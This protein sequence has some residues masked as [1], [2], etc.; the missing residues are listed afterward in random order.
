[1]YVLDDRLQ[2]VPVGVPGELYVAGAGVARGYL[3][4]PGLTGERFVADPFTGGRMYRTGD[5]VRW[6]PDGELLFVGRADDQ[7]KIRGYRVEPGEV[8]AV[9]AAHPAVAQAAVLVRE[10][11]PG[12]RRLIAYLVPAETGEHVTDTVR[13]HVEERLPAY[14]VPAAFVELDSLPLTGN[15]K[16]DRA[17]LPAPDWTA[18]GTGRAPATAQQELL[19]Q[20]FADVLDLPA[21]GSDDDFFAL[22]GHS[23]LATRLVGRVRAV[24]GVELPI[25]AL[26]EARTPA[27]LAD[28]LARAGAGRVALTAR[29]RPERVPLSFAQRRLWFL[30][31]LDGPSATYNIPVALRL[32]GH[33]DRAALD[34]AL[35]DVLAR[36]EVLRTGYAVADGEPYQRVLPVAETG[37][38]VEVVEVAA[39]EVAARVAGAAAYPFDLAAE[40]PLRAT[41]LAVAPDE[42]VLVLVVHHIAGDGASMAPL[43]ADV[44]AAYAARLRGEAPDW[45]PLPVQYADYALWQ[46]ELLGAEDDPDSLA[47][48][49]LDH[50]RRALAGVPE[51]LDLPADRARPTEAGHR[52]HLVDLDVP[53]ELHDRLHRLARRH[54][55]T[56]YM[57]LQAG[58]AVLLSR[59]GAGTDVPIGAAVAGRTDPALDDLV[60]FFVNT[61]V[62]RTDLTGDPTVAEVLARVRENSLQALAHQDVPFERLVEELAP[63][64]SLARHPL[65]QVML[66]LQNADRSG[67]PRADL[68]GLTATVV[69]T[70]AVPAKFD[71][72]V[73]FDETYDAD[74][75]PAGLRGALIA[76]ADLFEPDTAARLADRLVRMLDALTRDPGRRL[77][78]LPLLDADERRRILTEW[79]AAPVPVPDVTLP[80]LFEAQAARTPDA[81]ALTDGDTRLTYA[82]LDARADAVARRLVGHGVGPESLV[83]VVMAR[84]ADLVVALLGVL[85]AGAAY[86]PIDPAYPA[87]RIAFVLA[88]AAAACVLTST[89]HTAVVPP[90][91]PVLVLDEPD[92]A[93][94]AGAGRAARIRPLRPEHPAYVIYTSGSTGTPK[95]VLVPHRDVVA[96]FAA[97]GALF[98]FRADDVWSWFHSFAFDFSV[99]EIWGGL[100]H[101]GR[102][103]VVPYAVSRSPEEFADL[104]AREGVTMLSQTPSAFY[105]LLAAGLRP[106]A[107]RA[108]VFGGEALDPARLAGWWARHGESGPRLVNMY[109]ITET[110]VHV[111][112]QALE[113][114]DVDAGS[115]IGRG[116]PGLRVHL[117]DEWLNPVP[118]GVVGELYV[119][120]A[121]LARGYVGRAGLT[122]ERFVACPFVPGERMYRTGDR[123]RWTTDG[124]LVF[125]GRAD[126]QVKIRGFRIEPGEVAAVLAEHPAV[127]QAAVVARRDTGDTRLVGYL[128]PAEGAEEADLAGSV[129]DFAAARL[130][131]Y[132]VPSALVVLA[133]L[134]LTVNGKLDRKALPAPDYAGAAGAGRAPATAREEQICQAFAEVL[135]IDRVGVDDDFFALGG[136]S[137]LAVSLVERLRE[138]GVG[139]SVRA[140]FTTPTP[141]GLA[142]V[143]G[144]GAVTV[145]PNLIPDGADEIT[146]AML[147]LVDL[148]DAEVA[149]VVAAV[150]GGAANVADVYPLAP[151]QE[152]IF[153][154]HLLGDG[155]DVY[156]TPTVVRFD[157]RDRLDAFLTALRRVVDRNDVYRTAIVHEGLREPVQV[158]LRHAPLPV[159]EVALDPAGADPVDQ[160]LAAAG[161]RM[162]L[163]TAPLLHVH[164]A[165]EA[166][167]A[168]L[169]L[170]RVHHLVQDHTALDVV[171][172]QLQAFLDGRGDELPP[173]VP[174]REF[175]AQARLGLSREAHQ[176]HFARLLGDVTEPTA[177]YGLTDVH[178]DG[179]AAVHAHVP[180]DD[181]LAERIRAVA[182]THGVSPATVFHLAWARVLGTVSGRD[183]VVFGSVL[184]GRMNAGAGADR[185][186]GLFINT[187]PVRVRLAGHAVAEALDGL[188]EQ[189]A[190]LLVHEHAP[191]ALAQAAS[192]LPGGSPVFTSIFN[193]RHNQAPAGAGDGMRG[194][195]TVFA[196]EQTNYPLDVAVD[197]DGPRFGITATAVAPVDPAQVC[198]M[199]TTALTNLVTAL[200]EAPGTPLAAIGV[201]DADERRRVLP[202]PP[203]G[204]TPTATVPELIAARAAADPGALAVV[205][206]G[207]ALTYA[208]LDD[209]S[210]RLAR[211]LLARGL[212]AESVVGL[213]LP[214]GPEMVVAVVAA[215]RAGVGYVPLDPEY[216]LDRLEFMLADSGAAL[217]AGPAELVDRL[218]G[219]PV[220]RLDDLGPDDAGRPLPRVAPEQLA[221]VIYT[222]GSTGRPK[223]VA[224]AHAA[225]ASMAVHYGPVL[226]AA[227]GVRVLQFASF[228]FDASVLDVAVTLVAGGTLVVAAP[229][230]RADTAQLT[231]LVRAQGVTAT[232]VVPSLLATLDPAELPDVGTILV[233]AEPISTAQARA[234]SA[235]RNLVNTY[236]P[237]EATVMVTAGAVDVGPDGRVP[238][239]GPVTGNRLVVLDD[240]LQPVPVGVTGELYV[241]GRQLARGYVGRPA[242]TAER[243]VACP[244]APGERMYRTGDRAWWTADGQL[245][246]AGRA[247]DQVKIRGFRIEPGEVRAVLAD[248][249]AVAQAAVVVRE[250][251]PGDPRLVAYL[252]PAEDGAPIADTV[253]EHAAERLPAYLVPAAFVTL[254]ALPLT[255]NGKLDRAALPAPDLG[256]PA[257]RAP[258]DAREELLCAAFADVLG[259]DRVAVDDDFFTL[260][261]H[262]LLATRLVSRVRALLGLEVPIRALFEARTP[263]ALAARLRDARAGRVALTARPRPARVPLS[264][265]QRRLWFLGQLEGPSATYDIPVALRLTGDLDRAALDA[266]V[267]DVLDR[268]EVLRTVYE[269]ADG[270]PHQRVLAVAE[271]GVRVEV[272]EVR[273]AELAA[274]VAEAA[275]YPFDLAAEVP[276]RVTLFAV[277]PDEHVLVLVVH[278]IAADGWS[279]GPLSR[280]VAT[281]YAARR[282]GRTPDWTPL[283]VQYADYALW[284]RELLGAEDDPDSTVARQV[285]HWRAVLA[286][287]PEELEL[288]TDRPRPAQPSYRGHLVE[289]DVPAALHRDLVGLAR[290]A[291]V[292]VFMAVQAALAV[293]LSRLGAGTDVPIGAAV[294]GR[295]D[296]GLD[297]LVGFFVNTLVM[298]TDLSGDPTVTEL[299]ARVRETALDAYAH[300]DVPFERLVEELAPARSLARH[301]LFQVLLTLQNLATGG[302]T[303][304]RL[305][306]LSTE[307]FPT[308]EV[309][310]KFDLDVSLTE[311]YD[312]DGAPAGMRGT[313]IAAA[314]LFDRHTV[315]RVAGYLVRVLAGLAADPDARL[316]TVDV[317]DPAEHRRVVEEWN[318]TDAPV[319]AR[320]VAD[321]IRDR[322][323]ATPH[324]LALLAGETRLDHA[325][326]AARVDRLAGF[327][328]A[329]GARPGALVAICLDRT[330]DLV[331]ALLAVLRTGA[332]YLPID[333]GYPA[334][335]VGWMLAD[336][337]PALLLTT[338]RAR[339]G[340]TALADAAGALLLDDPATVAELA[341]AGPAP[342]AAPRPEHPAYVI[343]T[344]G[345][346]GRPKGVVVPHGALANFLAAMA[347]TTPLTPADR[348]LAVTT[349]AFD[350]HVLEL[351][352][353]LLAGA[354]VVLADEAVVRD[355]AAAAALIRRAGVTVA[356]AT[357]A[358]WHALAAGHA[359]ALAGLRVLVG[360]EALPPAQAAA[361][362]AR[363]RSVTNLY[364][365]TEVTVWATTAEL[366]GEPAG[367]VPIGRPLWNTRAYVLDA[368]L[369]PVPVGCPGELYLAGDQVAQGYHGRPDLTAERFVACPYGA[370]GERMYRTGDVVRWRA[371]GSLAFVG[372][373]DDQV[374]IR[375]F[376]IELG[377]VEAA[378]AGHPAVARATAV[379]REDSPG[380]RRLVG[381]VVPAGAAGVDVAALRGHLAGRLPAYLVPS[382][383]VV[384]DAL[385]LT[386]NGKVDRRALPAPDHA[387]AAGAGRAPADAREEL[388][389]AAFAAVLGLPAVGMDDDFFAL[390]GHSLLAVALVEHLRGLGVT[391][392]VRALFTTPTPAG[393]AAATGVASVPVPPNRIPD[394]ARELGPE[395]LP[396]VD[397]TPEELAT[398]VAA[399]PGGAANV[400]DV[401]PLAPLQEGILFHHLMAD[402]DGDDVYVLP[403]VLR[404]ATRDRLDDFLAALSAVVRRH[405][406]YRTAVVW[407]GLREPVQVVARHVE[408]P[409][410]EVSLAG[411][412]DP[413]AALLADGGAW[414][415]LDRPPLLRMRVAAEPGTG[416]WLGLLRIHHLVQDHTALEALLAEVLAFLTGRGHELPDPLPFRE[417][418]ARARHGAS[419]D[420]Q[421]AYFRALLGDV[422]ETT[423]P[424][425]LTDAHGDAADL[426]G[427]Q[428]L[429]ADDLATRVRRLGRSHGVSPAT[430]FH[431]AWARV[432]GT[433][434]GRDDVVFGTVL[435]G[436]LGAGGGDARVL[437]PFINTLPVRV[438]LDD[439]TGDA[440]AALR[441]QLAELLAHEHAPLTLAQTA[442]GVPNGQPLF[443][444]LFNFRHSAPPAGGPADDGVDGI[445]QVA[446][447]ERSNYPVTVSVD[448]LGE[449]FLLSVDAVA[450][451]DPDDV[452]ALLHTCLAHLV[453][454]LTDAPETPLAAVPVLDDDGYRRLVEEPNRTGRGVPALTVPAAFAAQ[455]ARTPDGVALVD[456]AGAWTYAELDARAGRLAR[457]LRDRGVGPETVVGVLLDRSAELV[458][459]LLAILK[460]GGAYLPVDPG[461]PAGRIADMVADAAPRLLLTT[462]AVTTALPVAAD[463]LVLDDPATRAAL[464]AAD[465]AG[466]AGLRPDHPAYVM[467]T[468]GSTGRP[469]GVVVP[470]AAIDRLV[471]APGVAPLGPGD[472]VAQLA[473]VSFDAAT[474]E[475]WGAL[476]T[477]ATLAVAPPGAL[478]VAEL[479]AFLTDQRVSTLWL[480]AGLFHEVVDADVTA[481]AGL[482][483]LLAGGD[484]LSPAHCRALLDRL[485]QVQLVNGYGPTE[486]TTF[487]TVHPVRPDELSGAVPIGAPIPDTSVYVL[488]EALRPVPAGVVGELYTAGAGLARGYAGP[489][490]LTAERFVA[491]PFT[492]GERMYRTGDRVRR[493]PDGR[494]V[495]VGRADAQVKLRGFRVE[496][497]EAEAVLAGHPEV[498]RAV[499]TVREDTPGEKR[500]VAYVVP[501]D[502]TAP[503][504]ALVATLRAHAADRLP[505]YLLPA[506]VVPLPALPLTANGKVDRAALP[507]PEQGAGSGRPAATAREEILCGIFAEVLGR[508]T[509]GPDDDF[510]ALGGHSLLVT[511][512]VSRVRVVL[513]AELPIR[514][515]FEA[516]TPAGLADRLARAA[517]PD[518]PALTARPRPDRVPLSYAQRRLWFLG[519]LEGPNA[520]YNIPL[521]QRIDGPVDTDALAAA[522][523]DVVGRHEVLRTVFPIADGEPY[524]R[525]L[526]LDGC[527]FALTVVRTPADRLAD[528]AGEAAATPFDLA[529]DLP[530][531]AWLFTAGP[532]EHVLVLLVHHVAGDGWSMAPLARDLATAYAARRAGRAPEWTP[533]PVQYADYALWQRDLLGADDD[534][535]S[536]LARQVAYWRAALDGAPEEL[537][538]P[539]DR[540]RPAEAGHRGHDVPLRVPAE[541]HERLREVARAEGVTVFMVLQAAFATLLSRLGAGRDVPIGSAIAGRTDQ[542]LDELVGFFVNTLV[543][544]TDLS[545]DPTFRR[546]L[547][548]VR[549]T[550]LAAYENQDVPFERLVEELAPARSLARH[551]IFQVMLTLQNTAAAGGE[552]AGARTG[553]LPVGLTAAKFDLEVTVGEA[554][555][556]DGTPAGLHGALIAAADLFDPASA[557]RI[558]DRLVRVL[559]AVTQ[560]PDLRV[561]QV[562]VLDSDERR[563]VL[564][565]WN[566]SALPVPYTTVP[567]LFAAQVARTPDAT[568]VTCGATRLTYAELDAR[569]NR[570]ARHLVGRGVGPESVVAVCLPR[571][572]DTIAALL[573]V[574]KAGAAYLPVDPAYPADR[575]GFLLGDAEAVCVLTA[576]GAAAALPA[577]AP[578]TVLL[579]DPAVAAE[580]AGL[581]AADLTDADRR[582]PLLPGHRA[583][584]IYTSG[585]TGRPKGVVVEHRTAVGLLTWAAGAFTREEFS[586]VLAATSLNFDVSVFELFGPLVSGGS[587][588]VVPDL[589]ALTDRSGAGWSA[590]LISAVPS[591]LSR[592]LGDGVRA[593]ARTV[594]L[595]GEALTASAVN[596]VR[597]ALPGVRVANIY[598]PTEATVYATAWWT[599]DDVAGV[600]PVGRPIANTRAY[601]L[602][603]HLTPV[604][605]GVVGELYLAGSQLARGYLGRAGLTG[606]RFVACPFDTGGQRMYRT[607]D[608]VRWSADGQ[609][610]FAGRVDE[611]VK[612]RG[613]RIEP[614]EVQAALAAHPDVAEAVVLAR[615]DVPGDPRLVGYVVPARPDVDAAGLPEAAR[616]HLAGRLPA[617]LVPAAVVVLDA[618]PVT[619]NGK[620]DRRALPA[621]EFGSGAGAGRGP[622]TPREEIICAVFAEVLGLP[623]VGVDDDFFALGGHSLLAVTLVERLRQ[624]GVSVSVRALFQT[625]TVAGLAAA[626]GR[627]QLA[628]PANRIP[629]GADRITPEMLPLV[630]LTDEE[631]A[632][633]VATVAGGAANVA[634]VYP[635]APLQE[636]M[637]FH[638]LMAGQDREDVYVMPALVEFDSR[639][640]LDAFVAAL[641][642]VIDRN[643]V[644]R[645][646][647]VWEGL[648]EAVQVV[649]RQATLPV[650]EVTLDPGDGDPADRL[651]DTVGLAMD[652]GAAPLLS[653]HG[654]PRPDGT[655]LAL[656][657]VHHMV[658]DHM[659]LEV[660]L[661][662]V[663]AILLGRG[664]QLPP[665]VPFRDF[666]A[667][668]RG[669]ISTDEHQRYFADLLGDVTEPTAPYGLLDVHGDG[670]GLVRAG[671]P[672]APEVSARVRDVA[673]RL[674]VSPATVLH[675]AWA[676]VL[677]AV[678]GRDDV[679]FGTIL[680]GRL[681]TGADRVPG[682]FINT[683]PVRVRVGGT[684]AA[685]AVTAMR[686]QLA[687]L[688]EHEHALLT[689]AQQASGLAGSAPLFTALFNYRHNTPGQA[690]AHADE[691][692]EGIRALSMRE[693]TNYPM[694]V[695]IDDD[696]AGLR[697]NVNAVSPVRPDAVCALLATA[698]ANLV[699][700]L[701]AGLDGG[702]DLPL[703]GVDVLDRAERRQVL[704][705]WN[706]T[707]TPV[708]DVSVA[709]AFAARVAADPDGIAVVAGDVSLSY[710][711]LDARAER[712]ARRLVAA[713]VGPESPV[714]VVLE[715]SAELLVALLAVVRAGGVYLPLDVAWPLARMRTVAADAGARVVLVHAPTAAH[716]FVTTAGDAVVLAADT[717]EDA[718]GTALPAVPP[719]AAVYSMYTSGSTGVPKGVVTTHRDVV[720]LAY[721]RGWGATPRVLFHAPHAFDASTY[722]IWVPL[723]SGGTVVVAPAGAIEPAVLRD[724]ITGHDLTHVHVTAGLL[725]VLAEQDPAC[726]AGLREVLTGGDVV[727][728][729]A[730]R[731]VLDA[732][733]GV[734]VRHMY[735]PTEITLCATHHEV[736]DPARVG[737]VLPIGRP[738]D[739]TRVYV[740]DDR[741]RPV[742]V[743][744]PGELYVAGAGVARGYAGRP[745][746]TGERF[747][748]D[749]YG[750]AGERMYRTGDQVRWTPDGELVFVGRADEQVKIRGYR[751]EPGEVEAVLAA[752][753]AVAQAAVLV[754]EDTPGDKRLVAYLVPAEAGEHVTD[755][756]RAYVEERLPAYLVP[757]A[758]VELDSLPLTGNGKLDR[759]ALPAPGTPGAGGGTARVAPGPLAVLEERICEAFAEVLGLPTVGVDDDF[760][761]LGGHSLLAVALVQR[762]KVRGIAVTVQEVMASPTVAGLMNALSLSSVRASLDVLLPIRT[763]GDRPPLFCV[764]PAGGLSWCYMPLARHVPEAYPI[765][766]LQASGLDGVGALAPS[767]R[768]MAADY[769]A[770]MRAVQPS[771]PYTVV[772]FSFGVAP[773]HE[774]AVQLREQGEQVFLVIM[775]SYPPDE[776]DEP[777]TTA[778]DVPWEELIRAEFGH[779]IAGFSDEEVGLLARV[780]QNNTAVRAGHRYRVFD[781]DA[782]LLTSTDSAPDGEPVAG[783]WARHVTGA[784][785]E[786]ALPCS[787][788]E[789]VRPDILG[790]VWQAVAAWLP[791][792]GPSA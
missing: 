110:T 34:A 184:F 749:P 100:L 65:F 98:D 729:P 760:F 698:T 243:F 529:V 596:R 106:G 789:L 1:M 742:P 550:G 188:R 773:A 17:A 264:F 224:V 192:G 452:C 141:A 719:S 73:S 621:P 642:Q 220:L 674:G 470:H 604:P 432:L 373:A 87:E 139:L 633:V 701:E 744:V 784:V 89:A 52:G 288:P 2:P 474:F 469:K 290:S 416:R 318:A 722:E 66:T 569:A 412:A 494:L 270:E 750:G 219:R 186:P 624:R 677:A 636:G 592:V 602:D 215:W 694:S 351:Y 366:G 218:P 126:D 252:V 39:D 745:G 441:V 620:L 90:G 444:A 769:V 659:G 135:G 342:A 124:R 662:E 406:I 788:D 437:G 313:L 699:D 655:W 632:A 718:P 232:S 584:V 772:G 242:L 498:A 710:A 62:M 471:R 51:E 577:G 102:V 327:L 518:R 413:V 420:E 711:E 686:D 734:R 42:H 208:E 298:R 520:T 649:W 292:T 130:P 410:E 236:G 276:L 580:L 787:H 283:P 438:R 169:A 503:G 179:A 609:L 669:G 53:A 382:T 259:L 79:N 672:L 303:A 256:G 746:P 608:R 502:P 552:L 724:L 490:G 783:R 20:V 623:A 575:I 160:L 730:V 335:R 13:A 127:G 221:Y 702:P 565:G 606:E 333:P 380:D 143:A 462:G 338:V 473:S 49:Q 132:L 119:A 157:S 142:A 689:T 461:Y 56:L 195:H 395:M 454:T 332:A 421:E 121:Q 247:D 331:V 450:P 187:L 688:L 526:P 352:L 476:L 24:F 542:G 265:A 568:A 752:H 339:A 508:P 205:G 301:P 491:C 307:S 190:D 166:G 605:P 300:Q 551:P 740:L 40:L 354:A 732:N 353:P 563:A 415:A 618:L 705:D 370:A 488:D 682:P 294:A 41:L 177:P 47:A 115:V 213:C 695:A 74:G 94:G 293:V 376:R 211:A 306:E 189:L 487:T 269:V 244:Y 250:D 389:C 706:D 147:P 400:A 231:A 510:F 704:V 708:A 88:D 453:D 153:F 37:F 296:Q 172:D 61:L 44:S 384:L 714:A 539:V 675:V 766:G 304:P 683:L 405:D 310:A 667:Q 326:L 368:A 507:A 117:L 80:D 429:V 22:G 266:A 735:G 350:I 346:T 775:D 362:T 680:F 761:T 95:G 493:D 599:D 595:A 341:E 271:T 777:E 399:V 287:A 422:T 330:A 650:H 279:M 372:R 408:L 630:E 753:P 478:S 449:R 765:Y 670:A 519:R 741:L 101:G 631:I 778:E 32:T 36:H 31:Q 593:S 374:K 383:V 59:L 589:L 111:T 394:G 164:V 21:V 45:P 401:Y 497:G 582:A 29:P 72:D 64:R 201:L 209:R 764:H 18:G 737:D 60:G 509:V 610:V 316:S 162:D 46:R 768:E 652:L 234:W 85:K 572:A 687:A 692:I 96:L 703:T 19:C 38:R 418:V 27:A 716:E 628:V 396:L 329:R 590:S 492:P 285:A 5:Q 601:V 8:E 379:V 467:F 430:L 668:A 785:T 103:V 616:G 58:L 131:G 10:E 159:R 78:A 504:D 251:T 424:Y 16:L 733:P 426:R 299:L 402:R 756:V 715:R 527:G 273:P 176:R 175:V 165:G 196:R 411:A 755:T 566:D 91:G 235:G 6:T 347:A 481:L 99:W 223:G 54:G 258:A 717:D 617:Y 137:L 302:G 665:P 253:R 212:G 557:E 128:V 664:D 261:G 84:T 229:A 281:A 477:G 55:V 460:A 475:I 337:A 638:H 109:G 7:V 158:V 790:Q 340:N 114:S 291:G 651:R 320:P 361:L 419:R 435:S 207:V 537:E 455:V 43:A 428:R 367:Q 286:G 626:V 700:A 206:D 521:A 757:A 134:P 513:G 151:L 260:G 496:P 185:V 33:L 336:A 228:S 248:H 133:A 322:A 197:V 97:T 433:L 148:T 112:Y 464:D 314:D 534:P 414:L 635:L 68:P 107:L 25:R 280:D 661:D 781:G 222:S 324:A 140:L 611:Q 607:G 485:P 275:A 375:G 225:L 194:M 315:E 728:A 156:V 407:A 284:Q 319:P 138:R 771:G 161:D 203:A 181:A 358:W 612:I 262:S 387:G 561:S 457:L 792:D 255:V 150:P 639:A 525:V 328:A 321:L 118:P 108:V 386:A 751:V 391:V 393:L 163:G 214:R 501:A 105:Q 555:D 363:A 385:P 403:T 536:V 436:R 615:Q 104:V 77:S 254:D 629:A 598:G 369:R 174:F 576:T 647:V 26:F 445:E 439:G 685:A 767:L 136:H 409:V 257:G 505:D 721:D 545:G 484:V 9:L 559:D 325:E 28:R 404:F 226:G 57:T 67:G 63:V 625:P 390:G 120:G 154:H 434:A 200:D 528:A 447:R 707:A 241:A 364:G 758:F 544:R 603:D 145:P 465:P 684:G 759:A 658:Q 355:P 14:L 183:D 573:G 564:A 673:R 533:L 388:F 762:L 263:A 458:V 278:H 738:L 691:E 663:R 246:F 472:V 774:I 423:A 144:G 613:F 311:A 679:V 499:V 343:Y 727:P 648:R 417:F 500:L 11:T 344:S 239:G 546:L 3:G 515:V 359:D 466:P 524:Q 76:A 558:A 574:W 92:P 365:P 202:E 585:S 378:L 516:P 512:L 217:V 644:Y 182:R 345:S 646:A 238:M 272:V 82:E 579:D 249:P 645:S 731:R 191:L 712:L 640:R 543:I 763:G 442:S 146:P 660:L 535:E 173:P 398:V 178:G 489:P 540:P 456:A 50:W 581:P 443:T 591:A 23:L 30:G 440:L 726:F 654:T 334:E 725:R 116:L 240:R 69:P 720:R 282:A 451:A 198:A 747:V 83:G 12:D 588:E 381:Y 170:L 431:L 129:R 586:R 541:V 155:A 553:G 237:T 560:D 459:A 295:T 523:R 480:T 549:A 152:G 245:V 227:P 739:N 637:L 656:L 274:R 634:D 86:L 571:S 600:P 791:D 532:T 15:G 230:E 754:R 517:A 567:A 356:Q 554:F 676:R 495:F 48:A 277:A 641:Q 776:D 81:V 619:A 587:I 397:L 690:A 538:L 530:V 643:D 782:L 709:E 570:I 562:D 597:G 71:L 171:L 736:T 267:R 305:P 425:G 723:L 4:R 297:D 666:V 180:V 697:V 770:R 93:A 233:G 511:R 348:L 653:I 357:P 125:A 531:R 696:G 123:A 743:G 448:D 681:S 427:A 678:A 349:V 780:V 392:P 548:R 317:L 149:T 514:A 216:P 312:P 748:A 468:S 657:R 578:A 122:G 204:S 479:R 70:G 371:D 377:E 193:Y 360:G 671:L 113:P 622:E 323:A 463:R 614:G 199:L 446:S 167:G 482:R 483:R 693:R 786:R 75:A 713:G 506:A 583:Y 779:V 35:R 556:A 594:V 522:L 210:A 289:V 547:A 309:P 308:D 168:W 627:E 268:H 486:N